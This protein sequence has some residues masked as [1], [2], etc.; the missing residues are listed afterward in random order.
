M[1]ADN[2]RARAHLDIPLIVLVLAM[3]AFGV[4]AV[5]VA[6]YGTASEADSW[7]THI[8]ESSYALKQLFF[9]ALAPV[10][11]GLIVIIPF[12]WLKHGTQL[13][14]YGGTFLILFTWVTNG[15]EGVKAWMDVF[16]GMTI[17]PSEFIKL[18]MILMLARELAKSEQPMS[19]GK[20]FWRI[21]LLI[22]V[23]GAIILGSGETGSLIVIVF[24][25]AVMIFFSNVNIK[26]I[27]LVLAAGILV[28]NTGLLWILTTVLGVNAFLAKVL[29]EVLLFAVSYVVQRRVVFR[30]RLTS[31]GDAR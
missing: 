28:V 18:A 31:K 20:E 15:A 30:P 9:M 19:T 10:I 29:V 26:L 27:L 2:R 22:L 14:Y 6:T 3:S 21:A 7:L 1:I 4:L 5:C 25:S 13:A 12:H 17:Q 8:L 23:P 16:W 24:F 11:V